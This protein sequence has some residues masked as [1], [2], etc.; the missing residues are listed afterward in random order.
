MGDTYFTMFEPGGGI[1]AYECHPGEIGQWQNGQIEIIGG[2]AGGANTVL[3][4]P[5]EYPKPPWPK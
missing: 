2:L 5:F 3:T 4:A 1:L